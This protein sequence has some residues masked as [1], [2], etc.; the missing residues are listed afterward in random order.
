MFVHTLFTFFNISNQCGN[1]LYKMV[2]LL[3]FPHKKNEKDYIVSPVEMDVLGNQIG[4][5]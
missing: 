1:P 3:L 5:T 4:D 2:D